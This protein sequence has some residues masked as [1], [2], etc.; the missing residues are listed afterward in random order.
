MKCPYCGNDETKVIDSRAYDSGNTIKRR[1]GCISCKN[2]FNTTEKIF[3]L[4]L[5]VIKKNNTKEDYSR[6]KVRE[7]IRRALVKRDYDELKLEN[8]LDGI[9]RKILNEY[10][11]EIQSET[12]GEIIM[13]E[14][15][16]LDEVAYVRFA[17]V[18]NKFDNLDNFIKTI[19]KVKIKKKKE[20]KE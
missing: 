5:K 8:I 1:R 20:S 14:L 13:N 6:H 3:N 7:G 16:Y 9:E 2:R 10:N 4:P 18:Y 15:F 12:L 11:G 17:S 19:K